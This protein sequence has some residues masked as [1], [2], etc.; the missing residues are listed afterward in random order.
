MCFGYR[1]D[2]SLLNI[3]RLFWVYIDDWEFLGRVKLV[4]SEVS[5]AAFYIWIFSGL[6]NRWEFLASESDCKVITTE[7]L[8]I[9]SCIDFFSTLYFFSSLKSMSMG[10]LR[11]NLVV[12][13]CSLGGLRIYDST[14]VL[15]LRCL[16][17]SNL[18]N[19]SFLTKWGKNYKI[20]CPQKAIFFS[21]CVSYF[22]GLIL[23]QKF[24]IG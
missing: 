8:G 15:P 13:G 2:F 24:E 6:L 10:R 22:I 5:S 4:K 11:I 21:S 9:I 20:C 18:S 3:T 14:G 17:V 19:W 7:E 1:W 12:F 23:L 16:F